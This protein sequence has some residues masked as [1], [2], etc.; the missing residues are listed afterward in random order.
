MCR[1]F[2]S[3]F[4][5]EFVGKDWFV[6]FVFEFSKGVEVDGLIICFIKVLVF[7]YVGLSIFFCC[8]YVGYL[9]FI[10]DG[11]VGMCGLVVV[12]CYV[13]IIY[14]FVFLDFGIG[15]IV[16]DFSIRVCCGVGNIC[17]VGIF[18]Y[19]FL[20]V[21]VFYFERVVIIVDVDDD[22][23]GRYFGFGDYD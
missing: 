3:V 15:N 19:G 5:G 7:V 14:V 23:V 2:G 11:D 10:D 6:D 9:S 12:C 13:D 1:V 8:V 18:V 20:V 4:F 21:W 16:L 22:F 17:C